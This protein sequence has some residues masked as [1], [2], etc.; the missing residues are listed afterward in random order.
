MNIQEFE[1]PSDKSEVTLRA[2]LIAPDISKPPYP[3]VVMLTGDGPKGTKSLSWTNIPPLLSSKGI[4]SFLFDFEGLGYSDGD[5]QELTITRGVS[6]FRTAFR[7]LSEKR[8]VD[9]GRIGALASSF[10]ATV[11][12]LLPDLANRFRALGL[13]S[14][15]A[16]LPDA[17]LAEIG[18]EL[19]D[20]WAAAGY[21]EKNG[22]KFDVFMDAL[23]QNAYATA[24]L[25]TKPCLI[26]HG[27][28]DEIVPLVQSI[29]LQK[30]LAGSTRLEIF[31]GVGHGYSEGD[32][33]S[34][35][36]GMFTEWFASKL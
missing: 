30:C 29:Y 24:K 14:P 19:F 3:T 21:L 8:W 1:F 33:W 12:L 11:L 31:E 34:R 18:F 28:N 7:F 13:K 9:M 23:E 15:A 10:G 36:A 26:T 17:Y 27:R 32:A 4:A 25:I 22:Y 2:R 20:K 6:N 16:F 35:M 5:R